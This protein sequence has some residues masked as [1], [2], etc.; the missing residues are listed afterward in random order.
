[1]VQKLS[2]FPVGINPGSSYWSDLYERI[3]F[4]VNDLLSQLDW[5]LVVNTPTTL[6][7]YGITDAST[8]SDGTYTPTLTTTANIDSVSAFTAFQWMRVGNTITVSGGFNIDP[9]TNGVKCEL[10]ISLPVA[11]NFTNIGQLAGSGSAR[12]FTESAAVHA[13]VTNDRA[14]CQFIAVDNSTHSMFVTFT[15]RV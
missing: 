2:P 5:N 8:S 9:T 11:V 6:A 13:D 7:G 4:L 12:A 10:G 1:M 15:Y 3:R 14:D